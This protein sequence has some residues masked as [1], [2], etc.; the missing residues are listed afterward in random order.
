MPW[1]SGSGGRRSTSGYWWPEA[2]EEEGAVR[3]TGSRLT[4]AAAAGSWGQTGSPRRGAALASLAEAGRRTPEAARLHRDD[5]HLRLRRKRRGQFFRWRRWRRL[6]W[7]RGRVQRRCWGRRFWLWTGRDQL[8]DRG[9]LGDG[10]V[11]ITYT[12]TSMPPNPTPTVGEDRSARAPQE[13]EAPAERARQAGSEA[14]RAM[15]KANIEDTK[16]RLKKRGCKPVSR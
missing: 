12:A 13:A 9:A 4:E 7:G 6:V 3:I 5:G 2:A 14:K 15:I 10:E 8:R 11:T 1:I 16:K